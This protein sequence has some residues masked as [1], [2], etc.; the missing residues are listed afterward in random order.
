MAAAGAGGGISENIHNVITSAPSP[1]PANVMSRIASFVPNWR[2]IPEFNAF[3]NTVFHQTPH[4]I[5]EQIRS[6]DQVLLMAYLD[7]LNSSEFNAARSRYGPERPAE[8][9]QILLSDLLC[10]TYGRAPFE[11]FKAIIDAGADINANIRFCSGRPITL[12][13]RAKIY[14]RGRDSL[15][16]FRYLIEMGVE[17]HVYN[18]L[19]HE[20]LINLAAYHNFYEELALIVNSGTN[21]T[22]LPANLWPFDLAG[23]LT[24]V[25]IRN[26]SITDEVFQQLLTVPPDVMQKA[27]NRL[28]VL[29]KLGR[30]PST[31]T[32]NMINPAFTTF[33]RLVVGVL[34]KDATAKSIETVMKAAAGHRRAYA[35]ATVTGGKRRN[36]TKK[37]RT[38]RT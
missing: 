23:I 37:R 32:K 24:A 14:N 8:D 5:V 31:I 34:G 22:R 20:W 9:R 17:T 27:M 19:D 33:R 28:A 4:Q 30:I 11:S 18:E 16:K 12:V 1:L 26:D 36:R 6:G 3:K 7:Y 15:E 10:D 25:L 21:I 13:L 29:A 38:R 35:I 2:K